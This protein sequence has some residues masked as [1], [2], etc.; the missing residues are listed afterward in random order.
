MK[1]YN[2]VNIACYPIYERSGVFISVID[3]DHA[4][5]IDIAYQLTD[6]SVGPLGVHRSIRSLTASLRDNLMHKWC[7][8]RQQK[9]FQYRSLTQHYIYIYL[10]TNHNYGMTETKYEMSEK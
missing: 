10:G 3:I 9:W 2:D 1:R 8:G 5:E 7:S 6:L 4:S